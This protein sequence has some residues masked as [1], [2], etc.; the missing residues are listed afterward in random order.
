MIR[1]IF[2]VSLC[3]VVTLGDTCFAEVADLVLR[4]GAVV[5]V[6][7]QQPRAEA[8][9]IR[10]DRIIAVGSNA[11]VQA[12]IDARTQVIE[13]EGIDDDP[14][15]GNLQVSTQLPL[16]PG[17]HIVI[18]LNEWSVDAPAT[19][20]FEAPPR[21]DTTNSLTIPINNVKP[22]DYLIR[23]QVDGADSLLG[24]DTDPN[25]NTFNW[26]NSPRVVIK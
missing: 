19:Y 10:R 4:G 20:L 22:G 2:C 6:D 17:Q 13:L 7:P 15:T 12:L 25:S 9:A 21:G 3:S 11:H 26:F 23:L 14:R 16:E 24:V 1:C 18:T 5:T 8:I